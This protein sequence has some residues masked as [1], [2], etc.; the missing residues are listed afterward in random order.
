[1]LLGG[2]Y[3]NSL[4]SVALCLLYAPLWPAAYVLTAVALMLNFLATKFAV[5]KWWAKPPMVSEEMMEKMRSRLGRAPRPLC[6][7]LLAH[8]TPAQR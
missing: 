7:A 5:S 6:T 2:L 3:A 8:C 1:M 4:K